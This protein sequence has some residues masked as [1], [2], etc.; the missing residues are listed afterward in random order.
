MISHAPFVTAVYLR[1]FMMVRV[2][3]AVI[4]NVLRGCYPATVQTELIMLSTTQLV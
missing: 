3:E 4:L 2:K 1:E